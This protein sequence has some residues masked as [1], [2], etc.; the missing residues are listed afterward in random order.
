MNNEQTLVEYYNGL[1]HMFS[2]T[3]G[4][5]RTV[6]RWSTDKRSF[7]I[8]MKFQNP[9]RADAKLPGLILS[10]LPTLV[11]LFNYQSLYVCKWRTNKLSTGP[12]SIHHNWTCFEH[13]NSEHVWFFQ[14]PTVF[15]TYLIFKWNIDK[16][17][18][19]KRLTNNF[20]TEHYSYGFTTS[21]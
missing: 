2:P 11:P 9:I 13:S 19:L 1:G 15:P 5:N 3:I 8:Y 14:V 18:G 20:F 4:K 12:F 6:L 16:S 7:F 21:Y 10:I 17:K